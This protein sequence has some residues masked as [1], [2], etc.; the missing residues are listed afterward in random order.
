MT[1][2]QV[3]S[4]AGVRESAARGLAAAESG[5]LSIPPLCRSARRGEERRARLYGGRRLEDSPPQRLPRERLAGLV[6]E[7]LAV[8]GLAARG[9]PALGLP[10]RLAVV[11]APAAL[12]RGVA[13]FAAG[14]LRRAAARFAARG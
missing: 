7:R 3:R 6:A 14:L 9:L 13:V 11:D 2:A 8:A 12:R 1:L 4:R 5:N 10:V